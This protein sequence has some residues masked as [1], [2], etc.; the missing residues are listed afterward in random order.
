MIKLTTW[1][2]EPAATE[3]RAEDGGGIVQSVF[4]FVSWDAVDQM[5]WHTTSYEPNE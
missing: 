1:F 4:V 5:I 3:V 2:P